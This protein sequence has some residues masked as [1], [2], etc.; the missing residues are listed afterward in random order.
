M[1]EIGIGDGVMNSWQTLDIIARTEHQRRTQVGE[2]R[3]TLLGG[4]TKRRFEWLRRQAASLRPA[5][6][7]LGQ[8]QN[9]QAATATFASARITPVGASRRAQ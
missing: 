1:Q 4:R 8:P 6:A 7:P 5:E 9:K 2:R 3:A